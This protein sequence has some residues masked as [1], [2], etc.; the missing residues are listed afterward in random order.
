[1]LS[2]SVQTLGRR[3]QLGAY[4]RG[5]HSLFCRVTEVVNRGAQGKLVSSDGARRRFA[6]AVK[7][8]SDS[9]D[10]SSGAAKWYVA[11]GLVAIGAPSYLV[12]SRLQNDPELREHVQLEYPDFYNFLDGMVPGGLEVVTYAS[13]RAEQ[14]DWLEAHELPWGEG[15]DEN[16]PDMRA[17]IITKR[18]SRY[19]GVELS[20]TDSASAIITKIIPLGAQIDDEVI[21]V[22]FEEAGGSF[23]HSEI[24]AMIGLTENMTPTQLAKALE[25]LRQQKLECEVQEA[26]W[27]GKGTLG[28]IKAQEMAK[29]VL[30]FE[31]E[32]DRI[33]SL[34]K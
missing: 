13:I 10:K 8:A 26:T 32:M 2:A 30:V 17:T 7:K 12:V 9:E 3:S 23:S 21:D 28:K 20:A 34:M 19:T 15:Y 4:C 24:E 14:S 11:G 27:R 1:M 25:I 29:K 6:Q 22:K 5:G 16:I 31:R 18:G 33:K